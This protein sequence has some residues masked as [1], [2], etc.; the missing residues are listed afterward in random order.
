MILGGPA[1]NISG[2]NL[3]GTIGFHCDA[4]ILLKHIDPPELADVL[5][6]APDPA[7]PIADFFGNHPVRRDFVGSLFNGESAKEMQQ[8]FAPIWSRLKELPF[9]AAQEDRAGLTI[10]RLAYSRDAPV[11]AAFNPAYPL[12]VQYPLVG[13]GTGVRQQL[14]LLANEG[15]LCRRHFAR[16][17]ACNKCGSARQNVYEACP[18]CGDSDLIEK[19]LVHHY[20][21]GC[22]E[23][24]SGFI[25]GDLLVCPKCRRELRHL[26]VDY[27][28]PGKIVACRGCGAVNS[29]PNVNFMCLDCSAVTPAEGAPATDWSHYDLTDLGLSS[30]RNGR[31]PKFGSTPVLERISGAYSPRD[32]GLIATQEKRAARQLKWPFSVARV[33]FP[34]IDVVRRDLGLV[35]TDAA[36]REAADAIV[37][38]VRAG[39]FV[40]VGNA[41]SLVIAF[42]GIASVEFG[43]IEDRIRKTIHDAVE[44]PLELKVDV[45][46]GDAV[47]ELFSRG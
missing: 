5:K 39:D 44:A 1:P 40:G 31:L 18:A 29:T 26:G 14:E 20:R 3:E 30:L 7:V 8:S 22:Q 9:R 47:I 27:G 23:P 45:A 34:N 16:T 10:L 36:I 32:F 33:T 21:C 24:E 41:P 2:L 25:Q 46:E 28:K 15:L 13:T 37:R 6:Q 43:V 42:P 19:V 12:I 11:K 38:M 35:A 17:H 4:V